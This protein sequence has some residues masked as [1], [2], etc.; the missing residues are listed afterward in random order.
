MIV[1]PL[2]KR[3]K[4]YLK[5]H[6]LEEKYK[7]QVSLLIESKNHSSLNIELLEPKSHGIYS[8]RIDRKYRALFFFHPD[9]QTI[10]ILTITVHYK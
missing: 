7:K 6:L 8:F 10:E 3:L 4:K 1:A 2:S 9:K 5:D